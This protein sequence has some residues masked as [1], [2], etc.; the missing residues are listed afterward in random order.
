MSPFQRPLFDPAGSP[1]WH[2][3][4]LV[5]ALQHPRLQATI[6]QQLSPRI[7]RW[8]S[9]GN[10]HNLW[11]IDVSPCWSYWQAQARALAMPV[12]QVWQRIL[13]EALGDNDAS[14]YYQLAAAPHPWQ[15]LLLAQM[16]KERKLQGYLDQQG[17]IG[18][19]IYQTL[20]WNTWHVCLEQLLPHLAN[21]KER[22]N[23]QRNRPKM[24]RAMQRLG[25]Q[26][27][28]ELKQV[29][30]EAMERRFGTVLRRVWDWCVEGLRQRGMEASFKANA[31][32]LLAPFPW[33][34]WVWQNVPHVVRHLDFPLQDWEYVEPLLQEDLHRLCLQDGFDRTCRITSLEWRL[35]RQDM[36]EQT[37][38]IKFRHPHAL[39]DEGPAY[40]TALLQMSYQWA[41]HASAPQSS[42]A[43][44]TFEP[45]A[46]PLVSWRLI[47][48]GTLRL[49]PRMLNLFAEGDPREIAL[50]E[51]ENKLSIPLKKF[52][53]GSSW[54]PEHAFVERDN[55]AASSRMSATE[56]LDQAMQHSLLVTA[57][58]RPLYLT[59]T[60]QSWEPSRE[61]ASRWKFSERLMTRWWH[62]EARRDYYQVTNHERRRLWVYQDREKHKWYCHG[63]FS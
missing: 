32:T 43:E 24:E 25:V 2:E 62:G 1:T 28:F 54:Q 61:G 63:Y 33:R 13:D 52:E 22:T 3:P 48:A 47:L 50:L 7:M 18:Q 36:S 37:I 35:M 20:T 4:R 60:P 40:K 38:P 26:K 23:L 14:P 45:I 6:A 29:D 12:E 9:D 27:P 49:P 41:L 39:H 8:H 42:A 11:L 34:E 44:T 55:A 57:R 46:S 31:G 30:G 10:D 15:A 19:A 21:T 53:L 58:H 59:V 51:L 17:P 16:M 56:D 5:L